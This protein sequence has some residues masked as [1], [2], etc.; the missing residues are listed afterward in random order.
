MRGRRN[1]ELKMDVL[2]FVV[3][4]LPEKFLLSSNRRYTTNAS[5]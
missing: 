2:L 5:L 4:C 1:V 3:E